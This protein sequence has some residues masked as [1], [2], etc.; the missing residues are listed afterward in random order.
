M[1]NR[2]L[3][4]TGK[5]VSP[6]GFGAMRLPGDRKESERLLDF[7]FEQGINYFDTAPDYMSGVS[8]EILGSV[9]KH[10]REQVFLASKNPVK[11]ASAKTWRKELEKSLKKM[12]TDYLDFYYM[13]S[14][15]LEIYEK[16]IVLPEGPLTAAMKA[17]EEGLIRHICFSVHDIR[18]NVK[19]ILDAG[20]FEVMLC[21]YNLLDRELES[22]LAYAKKIGVGTAVMGPVGGGRL[23]APSYVLQNLLDRPF[24]SSAETA[25]RFVFANQDVDLVLSGM[26][27]EQMVREN[28]ATASLNQPLTEGEQERIKLILEE[29][30]RLAYLYCTGCAYCLPCPAEV[31]IPEIFTYF[32]HSAVYGLLDFAKNEYQRLG[33]AGHWIKGNSAEVCLE[34]GHCESKCPQ[35]IPIIS[36]LKEIDHILSQK[37]DKFIEIDWYPR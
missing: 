34:C 19:Q 18:E 26:G 7:A 27:N 20:V 16:K 4:K 30:Q 35:K 31:N 13:W 36:R 11:D 9:F 24:A 22:M 28:I 37:P 21:Q 17:K 3:G 15:D 1:K 32:N 25:L 5:M 23:G 14:I 29:K 8:E 10:R 6:L 2:Q 33:T 12:Q